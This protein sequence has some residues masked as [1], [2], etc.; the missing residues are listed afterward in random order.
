M[1]ICVF[2][3]WKWSK[4]IERFAIPNDYEQRVVDMYKE[5]LDRHPSARELVL[6]V[7]DLN[8]NTITWDGLRQ[9]LMDS[10]EYD[11]MVKLQSNTLTPELD[12]VLMDSRIIRE[13]SAIYREI[14]KTDIP[15][16]MVLPLR[17]LYT[18]IN[19]NPFTLA[20]M[21]QDKQYETFEQDV[22]QTRDIDK[23]KTIDMF[24]KTFDQTE[25]AK[26]SAEIAKSPDAPRI[27]ALALT[28]NNPEV[29]AARAATLTEAGVTA[30]TNIPYV[31]RIDNA[32]QP[33][34]P[35]NTLSVEEQAALKN[36]LE[37]LGASPNTAC[38]IDKKDSCMTPMA[39]KIQENAA[40][41]F[42]IHDAAMRLEPTHEKDMVLRPEFA[43]SVPQ[44]RAP[45]CT[46]VGQ[47]SP[48]QPVMTNSSLL[49]G[50]PLD[51]AQE[52]QVG[53]IMPKFEFKEY[54]DVP[55]LPKTC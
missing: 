36:V 14:R 38:P 21:L 41:V 33:V 20:A 23:T 10:A 43:W 50:T 17:D 39:N 12:K 45:I 2:L 32:G 24:T 25:L 47:A 30:A 19:Y 42:N 54:V 28:N 37:V 26:A 53:S 22:M 31:E 9:H 8:S 48:T 49:L 51:E 15:S 27:V 16:D 3:L 40:R 1:S 18:T 6:A 55:V 7:R 35:P 5:V 4:D 29:V 34:T 46:T 11:R 13:I 44:K 52:T